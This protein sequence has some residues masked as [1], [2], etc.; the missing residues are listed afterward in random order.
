MKA[1][2]LAAGNSTRLHP[3][4]I[5]RPKLLI[6]IADTTSLI[7][8]LDQLDSLGT[9]DEVILV[10]GFCSEMIISR[11]G[12][13]FK[14]MNITYSV[15]KEQSGTASALL[16]AEKFLNSEDSFIV[17]MG[18]DLYEASDVKRCA[19]H[20]NSILVKEVDDIRMFGKVLEKDGMMTGILEKPSEAGKGL[21]NT[22]CYSFSRSIFDCIRATDKSER[23][24]YELTS[25]LTLLA[26]KEDVAVES[27]SLW[28]PISY[29][30]SLLSANEL[31][32]KR[33]DKGKSSISKDVT[34]ENCAVLKG[35]VSIGKGTIIRSGAYIE[36]PCVIGDN[37]SIGPNCSVRPYTT[38]ANNCRIGNAV[39]IKN[40]ILM[41][42]VN[43]SH[44]SY[45]G[46]SVLGENVSLGC[47]TVTANTRHDGA[48]VKSMVKGKLVDTGLKKLGAFMGDGVKTGINTSIYP[49]RKIWPQKTT[50]PGDI[51][52][53]DLM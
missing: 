26:G 29:P 31:L 14:D 24:E 11:L 41:D 15:Q 17:L 12:N 13:R 34:I 5:N 22:G 53:E 16:S 44:L 49:G 10:V 30:W 4:T 37:C 51:V 8:D 40:S 3:L 47:G 27:A 35:Y 6:P 20:K 33:L 1:V 42:N 46:D 7:H 32:L 50:R 23:G 21:A 45:C 38:I 48:S 43:V 19:S 39:E 36:G 9:I 2:V 25:A 28:H 52:S 18:D